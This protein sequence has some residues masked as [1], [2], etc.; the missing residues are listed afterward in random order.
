MNTEQLQLAEK[1]YEAS[2]AQFS[3]GTISTNELLQA[4]NSLQ[5][6]QSNVVGAYL[7]LRLAELTYL[8]SI[9]Q[10]K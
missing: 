7:Q 10:L 9:S 5:M 3:A 6:A 8:K 4:D 1:I 2:K